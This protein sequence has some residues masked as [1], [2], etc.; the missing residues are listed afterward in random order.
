ML[1]E[2]QG[3]QIYSP[4]PLSMGTAL[5]SSMGKIYSLCQALTERAGILELHLSFLYFLAQ[6]PRSVCGFEMIM[7]HWFSSLVHRFLF[8]TG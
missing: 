4:T 2:L 3:A 6:P 7:S 1:L 5:V 8:L